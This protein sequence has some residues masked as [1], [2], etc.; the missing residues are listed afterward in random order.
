[1]TSNKKALQE[2][3]EFWALNK[4]TKEIR[5]LFSKYDAQRHC[6]VPAL[7]DFVEQKKILLQ[8][9]QKLVSLGAP[10]NLRVKY[11][12]DGKN[13]W[14]L[15]EP[16]TAFDVNVIC[17]RPG[18]AA[19][20]QIFKLG[21]INEFDGKDEFGRIVKMGK[22]PDERKILIGP[23]NFYEFVIN[24][25]ERWGERDGY[26]I[27]KDDWWDTGTFEVWIQ[28]A[29]EKIASN[30]IVLTVNY[31]EESVANCL[32]II[33][34]SKEA[35]WRRKLSVK[36][37]QKLNPQFQVDIERE[38]DA[39]EKKEKKMAANNSAIEEFKRFWD[40]KKGSKE[41]QERLAKINQDPFSENLYRPKSQ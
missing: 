17:I 30:R 34:D 14:V 9:D 28:D 3:N 25:G 12:N 40:E 41:M 15:N 22:L 23:K 10:Y 27:N 35:A 18:R 31:T 8:S 38:N 5:D 21:K 16:S 29:G 6:D 24:F 36:W 19:L 20:R 7:Q 37:L 2:F 4:D 33:G 32:K 26:G 39:T 1:M 11:V 13:D